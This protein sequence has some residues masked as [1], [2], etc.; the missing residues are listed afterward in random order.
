LLVGHPANI[1]YYTVY[2]DGTWHGEIKA[3]AQSDQNGYQYYLSD[4]KPGVSYEIFVRAIA[5]QKIPEGNTVYC[6]CESRLSNT[7]PVTCAA[8]PTSP[9]I[10]IEGMTPEG[11]ILIKRTF[12]HNNRNSK[13]G[14]L[15]FYKMKRLLD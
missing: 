8:P 15:Y 14:A 13:D 3:N 9:H 1:T 11:M 10:Y 4:L 6:L 7:L 2:V 5:G 12:N